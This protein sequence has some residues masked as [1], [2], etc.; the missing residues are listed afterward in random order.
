VFQ[1]E[2]AQEDFA[3]GIESALG[4]GG[5]FKHGELSLQL[6]ALDLELLEGVGLLLL[7]GGE[8]SVDILESGHGEL[9][10]FVVSLFSES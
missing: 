3:A 9:S 4:F 1:D 6:G 8:F 5:A 10:P 2:G 7:D